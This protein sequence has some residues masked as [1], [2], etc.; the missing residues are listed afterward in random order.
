[1]NLETLNLRTNQ[2]GFTLME[3]MVSMALGLIVMGS[4]VQLFNM[5]MKTSTVISQRA[6]LQENMRAAIELMSKDISMAGAGIPSG[7]IQLPN[8][9][10]VPSLFACDQGGVCHIPANFQYP[11]GNHLSGVIPG[12][13]TG[14]E[15][16]A[17]IPSA[18]GTPTSSI[19][20]VYADYNFPLNEYYVTF[21]AAAGTQANI[22]A[23]PNFNPAPPLITAPG[24][25]QVG[26][27]VWMQNSSGNA[28]GEVTGFTANSISF[29]DNDP[30][31]FNQS[32]AA[33]NFNIRAIATPVIGAPCPPT[34]TTAYRI[35]VVT[36]YLSVPAAV[37]QL[38][39]LMRQ[40]NGLPPVPVADNIINM[41]FGYD[42]YNSTTN[43]LDA[44]QVNPIGVGDD[45]NLIQKVNISLVGQA[46]GTTTSNKQNMAL[47]TSV[48]ARNMAFRDR[49]K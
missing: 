8:N 2:R 46:L 47:S 44:N 3:L 38:P 29:A 12:F 32:N 6:E 45:L 9:G 28:V 14:V 15:N 20:L 1:M 43:A 33:Y 27:L 21:P 24:G 36:Y 37:G 49:Y 31:R 22:A 42:A 16:N 17:V 18:P 7:G 39:R 11:A 19:T 30:L 41:Q 4:A 23:N 40:V 48:S 26:D 13:L 25:L 5:G 35:F 10:A 34:C